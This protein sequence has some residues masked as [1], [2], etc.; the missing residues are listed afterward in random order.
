MIAADCAS[1]APCGGTGGIGP[2]ITPS[3]PRAMQLRIGRQ[4][5]RGI[6]GRRGGAAREP[7]QPILVDL[8][9]V[10]GRVG[11]RGERA[12]RGARHRMARSIED[13]ALDRRAPLQRE[14][15][16]ALA[17][18]ELEAAR[19]D[20]PGRV[21]IRDP[22][23]IGHAFDAEHAIVAAARVARR[24]V[25][26]RGP[27]LDR[28]DQPRSLVAIDHAPDDDRA[29]FEPELDRRERACAEPRHPHGARGERAAPRVDLVA[30]LGQ[31]RH[32]KRA[33]PVGLDLE[34][35]TDRVAADPDHRAGHG[36]PA[37]ADGAVDRDLARDDDP[38]LVGGHRHEPDLGGEEPGAGDPEA[39]TPRDEAL[40]HEVAV[41]CRRWTRGRGGRFRPGPD[42]GEP[43]IAAARI[44]GG[45]ARVAG[46]GRLRLPRVRGQRARGLAVLELDGDLS[47]GDRHPGAVDDESSEPHAVCGPGQLG[48][49][50]GVDRGAP[51]AAA[52]RLPHRRALTVMCDEEDRDGERDQAEPDR[53]RESPGQL[54]H[55]STGMLV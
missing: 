26:A 31:R 9:G 34:R 7:A 2:I 23:A 8:G 32:V 55:R 21:R 30:A 22:P 38:H 24:L 50:R 33:Q 51:R 19:R 14:L 10:L 20:E 1:C 4:R 44:P 12:N 46:P 39:I 6:R 29:G 27:Q 42:P 35:P 36:P 40:D 43:G 13:P 45:D 15:G 5:R 53:D 25:V 37:V 28:R 41:A 54:S 17:G 52:A 11:S 48:W 16:H 18:V 47:T 49:A 3:S